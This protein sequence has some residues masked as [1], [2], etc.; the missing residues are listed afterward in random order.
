M[1]V[2]KNTLNE[3]VLHFTA[4]ATITVQGNNSVSNIAYLTQNVASASIRKIASSSNSATG[5][6]TIKRG[7]NVVW[8]ASGNFLWDFSGHNIV[9]NQDAIATIV[10]ELTGGSGSLIVDVSKESVI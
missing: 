8:V 6:W 7:A 3:T 5:T 9:L 10:V 2:I 1:A 4:N